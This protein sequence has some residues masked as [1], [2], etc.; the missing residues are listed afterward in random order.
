[1]HLPIDTRLREQLAKRKDAGNWRKLRLAPQG[2]IDFFSNDYLGLAQSPELAASIQQNFE[3][4]QLQQPQ[5]RNGSTG[6]RL[7]SG[8]YPYIEQTEAFLAQHFHAP[9]ALFFASGYHA[10]VALLSALAQRNDLI[11]YDSLAH[12]SLKEGYRLSFARAMPFR[13]NDCDDLRRKIQKM[14]SQVEHIFVVVESVYS[15]D[16]DSADLP[17][18]AQI[19]QEYEANLIVDEAHSTGLYGAQGEGLCVEKGCHEQVFAR[20]H[21]FGKA[22]GVQGAAI[23]G[24]KVLREYLVNFA[25]PFIYS[26]APP[27][28]QLV[29][30]RTALAYIVQNQYLIE[31]L[32][33]N[34][35]HF[36]RIAQ[37]KQIPLSANEHPIQTLILGNAL[38]AKQ[39]ASQL[40]EAGFE[41][42]AILSPTV[43]K[44]AE[45]LRICLHRY[46]S[47]SEIE[48]LLEKVCFLLEKP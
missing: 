13:H 24:S 36:Q 20:I 15:M 7:L 10:N 33:K 31:E 4:A 11:L 3:A 35:A 17:L 40:Q 26:T 16:G 34:I 45:R 28:H 39:M 43:A 46:N 32:Q 25:L 38:R 27:L 37:E 19:C 42:R 2:R 12:A 29:S 5:Q 30:V 44:G 48:N 22:V 8:N 9:A 47:R 1:M 23:V 21:T 41:L 18:L 14:R 6:S